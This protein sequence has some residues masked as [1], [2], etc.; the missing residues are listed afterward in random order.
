MHMAEP[1]AGLHYRALDTEISSNEKPGQFTQVSIA[2][3]TFQAQTCSNH[4][5]LV[6][7]EFIALE[8]HCSSFFLFFFFYRACSSQVTSTTKLT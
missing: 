8:K 7:L 5:I 3:L 4:T 1:A 6:I 2:A